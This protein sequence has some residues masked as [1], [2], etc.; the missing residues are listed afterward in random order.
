M[1]STRSFSRFDIVLVRYPFTDLSGAKIRPAVVV[2][3][4]YPS[5][6][7]VLAS[8][9]SQTSHLL[10]GEFVLRDWRRAGLH[11]PTAAKRGIFTLDHSLPV[12]T[13][14]RLS[15]ADGADLEKSIRHWLGL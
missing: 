7:L 2:S 3:P 15:A 11:V 9:T 6:D 14:G 13:L 5:S 4:P 1:M 8:L 10:P 12:K